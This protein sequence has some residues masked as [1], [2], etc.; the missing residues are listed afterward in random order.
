[1]IRVNSGNGREDRNRN[2]AD[3]Y[4]RLGM[5]EYEAMEVFTRYKH[6]HGDSLK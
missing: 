2:T 6:D 5:A 4:N 3:L 1:M